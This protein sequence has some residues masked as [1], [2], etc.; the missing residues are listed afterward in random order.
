MN[1]ARETWFEE[2]E[3]HYEDYLFRGGAKRLL[4]RTW[5]FPLRRNL[6]PLRTQQQSTDPCNRGTIH[7]PHLDCDGAM[8]KVRLAEDAWTTCDPSNLQSRY[9][10]SSVVVIPLVRNAAQM[11]PEER[12]G[13]LPREAM[14]VVRR[15]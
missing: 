2:C 7:T 5:I 12:L 14:R 13:A 11:L 1:R 15:E 8:Q 10:I 4:G 6:R 3:G 9:P